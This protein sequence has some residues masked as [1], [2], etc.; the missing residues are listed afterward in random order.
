M[1]PS[2][3]VAK[4]NVHHTINGQVTTTSTL[5]SSATTPMYMHFTITKKPLDTDTIPPTDL[6]DFGLVLGYTFQV[7]II[8]LKTCVKS[9]DINTKG[10]KQKQNVVAICLGDIYISI[11]VVHM[12]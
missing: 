8:G 7:R 10:I 4:A 11:L 5:D 3:Y 2:S 6:S 12:M 1:N 9:K